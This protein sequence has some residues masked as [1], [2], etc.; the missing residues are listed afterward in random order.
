MHEQTFK[1]KN[2]WL[3]AYC[4]L[5]VRPLAFLEARGYMIAGETTIQ[6]SMGKN[7]TNN[8]LL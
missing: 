4:F 7:K 8:L 3:H 1:I 6:F 2:R 5:A